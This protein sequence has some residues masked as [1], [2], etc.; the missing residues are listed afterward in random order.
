MNEKCG[1]PNKLLQPG[2]EGEC[3]LFTKIANLLQC[4][5]FILK[6]IMPHPYPL[7]PDRPNKDALRAI[8][9]TGILVGIIEDWPRSRSHWRSPGVRR[10]SSF[11]ISPAELSAM[12]HFPPG[13]PQHWLASFVTSYRA[14]MVGDI[15]SAPS[16]DLHI[17]ERQNRKEHTVWDHYV[18]DDESGGTSTQRC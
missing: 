3:H 17:H 11:S 15:F 4:R 16:G 13:W 12:P 10:L 5:T 14:D 1:R 7:L 6:N 9:L 8:L 18:D 2:S